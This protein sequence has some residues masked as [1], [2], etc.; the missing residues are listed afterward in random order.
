MKFIFFLKDMRGTLKV[1]W[2]L[3]HFAQCLMSAKLHI[4]EFKEIGK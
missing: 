3:I 2:I 1:K 4:Q